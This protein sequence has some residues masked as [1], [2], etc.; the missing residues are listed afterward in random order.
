MAVR[1]YCPDC[2]APRTAPE[3]GARV[4]CRNCD[5]VFRAGT[6]AVRRPV[7]DDPDEPEGVSAS[8]KWLIVVGGVAILIFGLVIGGGLAAWFFMNKPPDR[9]PDDEEVIEMD[10]GPNGPR[11]AVDPGPVRPLPQAPDG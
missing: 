1:V 3:F 5:R 8:H 6:R 7:L 2:H 4:R 10:E 11:P 9:E